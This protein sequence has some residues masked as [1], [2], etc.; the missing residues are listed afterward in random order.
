[1]VLDFFLALGFQ[2]LHKRKYEES[3]QHTSRRIN[4]SLLQI[5]FDSLILLMS[6]SKIH[7]KRQKFLCSNNATLGFLRTVWIAQK[8]KNK[9]RDL[10]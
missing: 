4:K 1:M 9:F 6:A 7:G 5:V 3:T 8:K 10:N 2:D